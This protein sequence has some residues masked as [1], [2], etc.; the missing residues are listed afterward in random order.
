MAMSRKHY[1][2]FADILRQAHQ[3]HP[4]G[5]DAI[6]QITQGIAGTCAQD[7]RHFRRQQFYDAARPE[8][9]PCA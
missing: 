9:T 8:A 4:E 3:D 5:R 6:D 1:R 7:N 2:A